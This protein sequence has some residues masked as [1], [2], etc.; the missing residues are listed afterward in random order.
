MVIYFNNL[1]EATV[2]NVRKVTAGDYI[3]RNIHSFMIFFMFPYNTV[4]FAKYLSQLVAAVFQLQI[5]G[6]KILLLGSLHC[7]VSVCMC[8]CVLLIIMI[9]T[10]SSHK[11]HDRTGG[12]KVK[13]K[14]KNGV[15]HQQSF[16]SGNTFG[17]ILVQ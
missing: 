16:K 7:K 12:S 8:A 10:F 15:T 4:V 13:V 5:I 6:P 11:N 3:C 2:Q 9:K 14:Q 17:N 1:S